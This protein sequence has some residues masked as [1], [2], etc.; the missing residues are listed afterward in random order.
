MKSLGSLLVSCMLI[1]MPLISN[2]AGQTGTTPGTFVGLIEA[3]EGNMDFVI[4]NDKGKKEAFFIDRND[5][6]KYKAW[7]NKSAKGKKVLITW[8]ETGS[9]QYKFKTL[10][11][12]ELA[13]GKVAGAPVGG[14]SITTI[15]TKIEG[16]TEGETFVFKTK[17]G[18]FSL[19]G[20]DFNLIPIIEKAKK[21][22]KPIVIELEDGPYKIVKSLKLA[23]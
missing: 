23:N 6:E 4:R 14:K 9:G 12:L 11:K 5:Y 22:K 16:Y 3:G 17:N 1:M 8:S 20:K 19:N 2:A 7:D 21:T 15:V 18:E 13:D 10:D